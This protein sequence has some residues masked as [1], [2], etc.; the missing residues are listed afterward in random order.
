MGHS[1]DDAVHK[2]PYKFTN[3][4]AESAET[5]GIRYKTVDAILVQCNFKVTTRL[6]VP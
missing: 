1:E 5:F 6:L 3:A 4:M 2:I